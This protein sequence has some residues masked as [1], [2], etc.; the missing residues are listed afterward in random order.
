MGIVAGEIPIRVN[1]NPS[2]Y[3]YPP[4][5][6]LNPSFSSENSPCYPIH[7]LFSAPEK[8]TGD[9]S[10]AYPACRTITQTTTRSWVRGWVWGVFVG[11][12]EGKWWEIEIRWAL[13]PT[14]CTIF[15]PQSLMVDTSWNSSHQRHLLYICIA[16]S[17]VWI[18]DV[19][20]DIST[21]INQFCW[22]TQRI[23]QH[24]P[25]MSEVF[26]VRFNTTAHVPVTD[27][28]RL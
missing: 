23:F 5:N 3:H 7:P 1:P 26:S 10:G 27:V 15:P 2:K 12:N 6:P 9:L 17:L 14:D 22:Y 24:G 25:K 4:L 18:T 19:Y 11:Q 21:I 16:N 28:A 8:A 13:Y 20:N